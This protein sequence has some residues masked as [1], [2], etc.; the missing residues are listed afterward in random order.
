MLQREICTRWQIVPDIYNTLGTPEEARQFL[1]GPYHDASICV[2]T[3]CLKKTS[4]LW[5]AI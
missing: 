1:Y 4:H 2:Y 5:L 3:P